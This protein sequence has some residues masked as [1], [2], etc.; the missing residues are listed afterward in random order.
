MT[1]TNN[2]YYYDGMFVT[3]PGSY[4]AN[5][6]DNSSGPIDPNAPMPP[7][8]PSFDPN[9][10]RG[11]AAKL[12]KMIKWAEANNMNINACSTIL[13]FLENMGAHY[14]TGNNRIVFEAAMQN[15]ITAGDA[16]MCE[17]MIN[18]AIDNIFYS[19]SG[20]K[21]QI[22]ATTLAQVTALVSNL[23][24][25]SQLGN[26]LPDLYQAASFRLA[27][28]QSWMDAQFDSSGNRI[29][30]KDTWLIF[31]TGDWA[32]FLQ[33]T[34]TDA[35]IDGYYHQEI[36]Q[37]LNSKDASLIYIMLIVLLLDRDDDGE[38]DLGGLGGLMHREGDFASQIKQMLAK[39]SSS[40]N[41]WKPQ[42]AGDFFKL[43]NDFKI[44]IDNDPAFADIKSQADASINFFFNQ[45]DPTTGKTFEQLYT[46]GD[47]TDLATAMNKLMPDPSSPSAPSDFYTTALQD[48]Q[49][50]ASGMTGM[51]QVTGQN[52]SQVQ[53]TQQQREAA[54][55]AGFKVFTDLENTIN[56]NMKS[57]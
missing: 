16:S 41:Q 11:M 9:D 3:E 28:L 38:S 6:G 4:Q 15:D 7:F 13:T 31:A 39:F 26:W 51:S 45:T 49:D 52:V 29:L 36:L 43:L 14:P 22:E 33:N 23:A 37:I 56:Q 44:H 46:S 1:T 42:D 55:G 53:G 34:N 18:I 5:Y 19:A 24:G 12:E 10:P 48:M 30:N 40:G 21:S 17:K 35:W 20:S 2:T 54:I 8:D 57:T 50:M 32:N 47:T 25:F 27:N